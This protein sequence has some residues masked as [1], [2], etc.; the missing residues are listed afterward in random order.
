MF[1]LQTFLS[2][3]DWFVKLLDYGNKGE[4]AFFERV[5]EP[6]YEAAKIARDDLISIYTEIEQAIDDGKALPQIERL[7]LAR[8]GKELGT[9]DSLRARLRHIPSERLTKFEHA[10]LSLLEGKHTHA[11]IALHLD[12]RYASESILE[13]QRK[14]RPAELIAARR[15]AALHSV[16]RARETAEEAWRDIAEGHAQHLSKYLGHPA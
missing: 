11:L 3:C 15:E 5:I 16:R 8:R 6:C 12:I 7:M 4:K 9:R 13:M 1:E 2:L 14:G 10:V